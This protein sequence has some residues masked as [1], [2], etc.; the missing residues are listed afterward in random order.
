M[1]YALLIFSNEAPERFAERSEDEQR[2]IVEEYLAIRQSP[3]VYA[4]EQLQPAVRNPRQGTL[5]SGG[6]PPGRPHREVSRGSPR[7]RPR[8]GGRQWRG[9]RTS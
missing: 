5:Q 3:G 1:K 6:H 7:R 9:A 8:L 2:A 4:G